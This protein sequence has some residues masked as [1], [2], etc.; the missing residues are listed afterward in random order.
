MFNLTQWTK[1]LIEENDPRAMKIPY[2]IYGKQTAKIMLDRYMK[3]DEVEK[4]NISYPG[5]THYMS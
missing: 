1:G 5:I 4:P 2:T 3:I